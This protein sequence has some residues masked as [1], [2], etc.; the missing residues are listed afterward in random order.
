MYDEFTDKTYLVTGATSGIGYALTGQLARRGARVIGVGRSIE[1]CAQAKTCLRKA[2]LNER[3]DYF[4]ADLSLQSQVRQLAVQVGNFLADQGVA[5][6]DGLVNNA[7]TFTYWCSLTAEGVETQWAVNHF[8]GYMLANALLPWLEAASSAR[9]ITVSSQSHLGAKI[10]WNDPQRRR[11]Y[12][13]LR[14]YGDTKLANL[15][16]TLGFNERLGQA[17]AVRADAVDPGLVNTEIG[18]K[19]TPAIANLVWKLRKSGG[20]TPDVP[21]A[22]IVQLL[23]EKDQGGSPFHYWKNA[24]PQKASR[25]ALDSQAADRLWAYSQDI[26]GL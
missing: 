7:G 19:G 24:R 15:L 6:L 22:G 10:D 4:T 23:A 8:A 25:E 16:F 14:V 2:A 9:V 20:T 18:S 26:C 21:A 5:G 11:R 13:G 12:N 3:I 17:S 1:K